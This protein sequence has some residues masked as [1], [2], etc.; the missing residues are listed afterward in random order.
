MGFDDFL[1]LLRALETHEVDYVL[2]GG[3]ALGVHGLV[4]AT[5]D[6]DLFVRPEAGNVERLKRALR[7][8]WDD[9]EI[10]QISARDLSGDYPTVRY[11]PPVA[12]PVVDL[13]ARLGTEI[14]FDDLESER[15]ELEGVRVQVAT[16]R[17]LFRMKRD[18]LR[19]IDRADAEAL[20]EKFGLEER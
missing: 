10:E 17:A 6:I 18:A 5:E 1:A 3:V 9:P 4:R 2:V 13:I 19:P 8:V 14:G 11:V 20:K 15:V 7:A 12:G 16:P